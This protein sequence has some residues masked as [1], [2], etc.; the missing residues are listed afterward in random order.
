[1]VSPQVVFDLACIGLN[2]PNFALLIPLGNFRHLYIMYHP[3]LP[4]S[5]F[6]AL[7]Q[8]EY[9]PVKCNLSLSLQSSHD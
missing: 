2:L 9:V 5:N 1:M 4:E 8:F 7:I 6:G 3:A